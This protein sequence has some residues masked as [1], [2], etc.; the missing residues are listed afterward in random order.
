MEKTVTYTHSYIYIYIYI[1]IYEWYLM[2]G[3]ISQTGELVYG[4]IR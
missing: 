4:L 3:K 1:Y 2:R